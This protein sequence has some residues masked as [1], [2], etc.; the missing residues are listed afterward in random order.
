MRVTTSSGSVYRFLQN[1]T[2]VRESDREI[3]SKNTLVFVRSLYTP[4]AGEHMYLLDSD[5]EYV[6]TTRVEA[7]ED[8]ADDE[9]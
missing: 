6:V 2:V 8:E 4:A 7:I 3:P 1:G 9:R 5:G